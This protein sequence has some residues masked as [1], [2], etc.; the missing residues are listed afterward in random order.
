LRDAGLPV[1]ILVVPVLTALWSAYSG[2][3]LSGELSEVM[4]S[5]DLAAIEAMS[6]SSAG[7]SLIGY[8]G[9]LVVIVCGLIPTRA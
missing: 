1:L 4:A 7:A 3:Q 6:A 2:I 9:Y 8:A 5:G